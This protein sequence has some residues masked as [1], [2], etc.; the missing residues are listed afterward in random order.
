MRIISSTANTN[1]TLATESPSISSPLLG[2]DFCL[3][4]VVYV[5]VCHLAQQII[6]FVCISV[7]KMIHVHLCPHAAL[8]CRSFSCF[9]RFSLW[10]SGMKNRF[11]KPASC[12][13][14]SFHRFALSLVSV[15]GFPK[16]EVRE[17]VRRISCESMM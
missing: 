13:P 4:A 16:S 3:F 7:Q 9:W 1:S 10:S 14:T 11:T 2:A 5:P 8:H 15:C 12:F 6:S 17:W